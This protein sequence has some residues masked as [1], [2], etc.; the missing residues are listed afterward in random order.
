MT[1]KSAKLFAI[2]LLSAFL[3]NYPIL[4]VFSKPQWILGFPAQL[5][6]LFIIWFLV[7]FAVRVTVQDTSISMRNP[8][9]NMPFGQNKLKKKKKN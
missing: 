5:V 7:I 9:D 2:F 1:G 6:Y 8:L 3:L 4:G